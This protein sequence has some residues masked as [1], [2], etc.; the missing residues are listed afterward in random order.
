VG[1]FTV[2]KVQVTVMEIRKTLYWTG[3]SEIV[4]WFFGLI[5]Y[6]V[7]RGDH[8]AEDVFWGFI[9]HVPHGIIGFK[10]FAFLVKL[11]T[12]LIR[13]LKMHGDFQ[14]LLDKM[15]ED[16]VWFKS[17]LGLTIACVLGDFIAMFV[18]CY[19][20]VAIDDDLG[21]LFMMALLVFFLSCDLSLLL[22][23][24][25]YLN[26]MPSSLQ[27]RWKEKFLKG[28]CGKCCPFWTCCCCLLDED[29]EVEESRHGDVEAGHIELCQEVHGNASD[30]EGK[31][32]GNL[33]GVMNSLSTQS[34]PQ[35]GG[36]L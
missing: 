4:V 19:E 7:T 5:M 33:P 15:K 22:S 11:E 34:Q 1:V 14:M 10:V 2:L 27:K 6:A 12:T 16:M 26:R 21:E 36:R 23:L 25:L 18:L 9:F 28:D 8:P 30:L 32:T 13:S 35:A 31:E 24:P 3:L 17:Y 20:L 29:N